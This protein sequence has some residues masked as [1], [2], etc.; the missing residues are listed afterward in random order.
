ME[1]L[2]AVQPRPKRRFV[3]SALSVLLVDDQPFFRTLLTEVLRAMGVREITTAVDGYDALEAFEMLRPDVILT[4]WV[5]PDCDG[6]ELTRQIRLL[7]DESARAVPIILVTANNQKSQIDNARNCGVDN[8]VLKPVSVKSVAE[9]LREVIERPRPFVVTEAYR[10][11]CRRRR[12]PENYAGPFRRFDD[13]MELDTPATQREV[14]RSMMELAAQRIAALVRDLRSGKLKNL[15]PIRLAAEEVRSLAAE[16]GDA[17]LARCCKGLCHYIDVLPTPNA[18]RLDVL[19]THMDAMEVLLK[20]PI[21]Q[22][23]IRDQVVI[24]L[25][26][27]VAKTVRAA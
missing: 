26:K 9:R 13:P 2:V 4:D 16:L 24:G 12:T 7:S 10:G 5:M 27:V 14:L 17:H 21:N 3:A 19:H 20:T 11:P 25:E 1:R 8:F 18:V 23:A 6:L 22:Q 15:S